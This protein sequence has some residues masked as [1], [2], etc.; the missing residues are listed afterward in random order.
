ME[1]R[2]VS[3]PEKTVYYLIRVMKPIWKEALEAA[4]KAREKA[5]APYS[6]FYVGA[7][8][9]T[10]DEQIITGVNVENASYSVAI[11]AERSALASAVSQGHRHFEAVFVTARGRDY[12]ISEPVSPCGVCR[13]A[14]FEFRQYAGQP[15]TVVMANTKLDKIRQASIDELLVDGFGLDYD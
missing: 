1:K 5:Y 14:L 15:L 11:C 7:A 2:K 12:D 6:N 13:Q 8:L 10:I 3:L 9:L 4:A